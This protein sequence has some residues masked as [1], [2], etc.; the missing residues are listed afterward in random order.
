MVV[1]AKLGMNFVACGPEECMPAD[2]LVESAAHRRG[3]GCHHQA[4][5]RRQDGGIRGADVI[6]TDVWV[7]MGEPDEVWGERIACS[8][9]TGSPGGHG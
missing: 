6:Y 2:D 8:R 4:D 9:R 5:R 3:D 1:C 7:S